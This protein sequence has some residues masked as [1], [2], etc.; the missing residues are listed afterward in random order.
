MSSSTPPAGAAA[1]MPL[2]PPS[3]L[4][5]SARRSLPR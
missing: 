5:L 2:Q 3:T 4:T 1:A